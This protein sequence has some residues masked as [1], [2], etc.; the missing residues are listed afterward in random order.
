MTP[1]ERSIKGKGT[2]A[3]LGVGRVIPII[4][5]GSV[6]EEWLLVLIQLGIVRDIFRHLAP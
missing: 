6:V 1:P 4:H 2:V 5:L 3:G